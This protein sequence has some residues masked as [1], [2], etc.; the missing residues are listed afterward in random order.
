[1]E[2]NLE[3]P[4]LVSRVGE[5]KI[6]VEGVS[7]EAEIRI[8][9]DWTAVPGGV[10]V[11][12]RTWVVEGLDYKADGADILMTPDSETGKSWTPVQMVNSAEVVV[13]IPEDKAVCCVVRD[14]EGKVYTVDFSEKNDEEMTQMV[15]EKGNFICWISK[16]E[17]PV[18]ITEMESPPFE[19]G[20]FLNVPEG[21]EE[22]EGVD[23]KEY[24][25]EVRRQREN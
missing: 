25:A 14:K 5:N 15:W 1:M 18:R 23:L 22:F 10:G 24:W 11:T 4:K 2:N 6:K 20:M 9:D 13:D 17:N 19:E 16:G 12:C 3:F 7:G 21:A 8:V